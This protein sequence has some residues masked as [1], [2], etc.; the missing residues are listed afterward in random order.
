MRTITRFGIVIYALCFSASILASPEGAFPQSDRHS[1]TEHSD[2]H[3]AEHTNHATSLDGLDPDR[4]RVDIDLKT[5]D[6]E[7]KTAQGLWCVNRFIC[8]Y[9][10][11]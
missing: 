3:A 9:Q 11:F 6:F 2:G 5:E 4:I 1:V 10:N 8:V 7:E